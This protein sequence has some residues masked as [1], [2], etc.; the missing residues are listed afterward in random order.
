MAP[1]AWSVAGLLD[2]R[3]PRRALLAAAAL[4][5]WDV[6]LDPRM[7]RDGHWTWERGGRYEDVPLSNFGGWLLTGAVLFAAWALLDGDGE[8][9]RRRPRALRVDV[10][11]GGRGEPRL[12]GAPARGGGG[13]PGDGRVR[14]AGA[15]RSRE[16]AAVRVVVVGAGVGGLAA[17]T[18]LAHAGHDVLVVEQGER[19][20]GKCGLV[21]LG[22]LRFDSGPSLLTMPQVLRDLLRD[23]GA[24]ELELLP[25][26]PVT[27]YRFADGTSVEL[28]AD[29]PRTV[30]ALEAWS[31][32]AGEDWARFLGVCEAMWAASQ[33]FLTGP[34]PFPPRRPAAGEARPDPREGLAVRP[35]LTL[36]ALA[37]SELRDPR[38]QMVVER[39]ATYA[40]CRPAARAGGA[41]ARGLR[42]ARLRRLA[43]ARRPAPD[44]R[45]ADAAPRGS[46]AAS[47]GCAPA[48]RGSCARARRVRGVRLE[49]GALERADAVV[50]DGDSLALERALRGGSGR[51]RERSSSGLAVMLAL[52]GRTPGM[53]HHE[54]RFP[55]DYDA[56]VR[57]PLRRPPAGARSDGLR[58]RAR[59]H[60]PGRRAR[61]PGGVVRA[62][63]RALGRARGLGG[64]GRRRWSRGSAS[65]TASWPDARPLTRGPR[66]RDGRHRR[67]DLR[68]GAARPAGRPA[69]PRAARSAACTGSCASAGPRTRAAGCRSSCSAARSR[70]GSSGRTDG[71]R[72][73]VGDLYGGQ[74]PHDRARGGPMATVRRLATSVAVKRLTIAP[75]A[76]RWHP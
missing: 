63:Q 26:E 45:G 53:A 56:R 55:A 6:A 58:Q 44:R 34:P 43:R 32:G 19:P 71:D 28:S 57:R 35:W 74:A 72:E 47:C 15:A 12:L 54:I 60:G 13:R 36:R 42:R 5:A 49:G 64:A 4:T 3:G 62:G 73:A 37:R 25:V 31:P 75:G 76:G 61:G 1:A 40:G 51:R 11:R 29:R 46:S 18:R 9:R 30:A 67:R 2:R 33:R 10:D 8:P 21:E 7:V 52:R 69:P 50:W 65:R 16:A 41:R 24:Q 68:R 20:G 22:G 59:G 48:R 14:R 38:L 17:A 39:F 66:A 23:V 70:R 27:R